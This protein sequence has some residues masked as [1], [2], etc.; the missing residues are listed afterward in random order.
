[1]KNNFSIIL[2]LIFCFS[3]EHELERNNPLDGLVLGEIEEIDMGANFV[4]LSGSITTN[5]ITPVSDYGFC[6]T[7]EGSI[8][9]FDDPHNSNGELVDKEDF[10]FQSTI[11]GLELNQVYCFRLFAVTSI[12]TV[13]SNEFFTSTEWDGESPIINTNSV[14]LITSNSATVEGELIDLGDPAVYGIIS[15]HGHCWSSIH[16]PTINDNKSELGTLSSTG[17]FNTNIE[18]LITSTTYYCRSYIVNNAG[19]IYGNSIEFNTTNGEP[20]ITTGES[21]NITSTTADVE[22]EVI[23]I[24]DAAIT[25]YGHCW[26]TAQNPTTNDNKNQLGPSGVS[27]FISSLTNLSNET[28]YYYRSYATNSYGTAYGDEK[29]FSTTNGEPTVITIGSNNSTSASVTL[30]GEITGIGDATITQHGHC[31]STAQNPTTNNN[32]NQLGPSGVSTFISSVSGLQPSTTYFYKSYATNNLGTAYGVQKTFVTTDGRPEVETVGYNMNPIANGSSWSYVPTNFQGKIIFSGDSPITSHGFNY[33]TYPSSGNY[34]ATPPLVQNGTFSKS[35]NLND[36]IKYYYRAYATN[37]FG[38]S[39]GDWDSLKTPEY[40]NITRS[41]TSGSTNITTT[42]DANQ[43]QITV[44]FVGWSSSSSNQVDN[45]SLYRNETF[46]AT[47]GSWLIIYDGERTF[48][49]PSNLDVSDCYTIRV[50]DG[51]AGQILMVSNPFTIE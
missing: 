45:I 29:V 3:C 22:G 26:S 33:G 28:T 37:S 1:M 35:Y 43:T 27:T 44:N 46:I 36:N 4:V 39:Y 38:T 2:A 9:T 6:W 24:G 23:G 51:N 20:S 50:E 19:T 25:Q 12:D 8:P 48:N 15:Q 18:S 11:S 41:S 17:T 49:L 5:K 13:Y 10:V 30:L 14:N 16:L 40:C 21:T 34:S 31:W 42:L 32:K 7:L 47:F